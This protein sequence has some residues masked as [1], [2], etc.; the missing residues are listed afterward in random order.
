MSQRSI[1]TFF[2]PQKRKSDVAQ[3]EGPI[4][5]ISKVEKKPE[6]AAPEILSDEEK[7]MR[8]KFEA[9]FAGIKVMDYRRRFLGGSGLL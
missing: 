9:F 6:K 4:S 7:K 5:K 8:A 1:N 2:K 3:I